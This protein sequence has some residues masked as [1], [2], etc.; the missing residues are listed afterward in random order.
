MSIAIYHLS[1]RPWESYRK[2]ENGVGNEKNRIESGDKNEFFLFLFVPID[3]CSYER[4]NQGQ[5]IL[6]RFFNQFEGVSFMRFIFFLL[7]LVLQPKNGLWLLLYDCYLCALRVQKCPNDKKLFIF[8]KF[9]RTRNM[10][11]HIVGMAIDEK[12]SSYPGSESRITQ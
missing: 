11:E 12:C 1:S 8:A 9:Q 6:L 3:R 7:F 2:F 5:N 10:I 4:L